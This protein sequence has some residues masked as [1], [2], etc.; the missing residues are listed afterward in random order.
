MPDPPRRALIPG[1]PGAGDKSI[2]VWGS[3]WRSPPSPKVTARFHRA[4]TGA[5]VDPEDEPFDEKPASEDQKQLLLAAIV[6]KIAGRIGP[7]EEASWSAA[8]A[9]ESAARARAAAQAREPRAFQACVCCAM[10]Q[11]TEHLHSEFLVGEKCTI[12]DRAKF[13]DCLSAEWYHKRWPL[14]PR[15]ELMS[16][17]VDFPHEDIDGSQTTTKILLHKRRV[18]P[19]ALTGGG[20]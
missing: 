7:E 16:S 15:E 3:G 9:E 5:T 17:A 12:K 1:A 4:Q 19:E 14:I 18:P 6:G 2:D 20:P 11:W 10:Q 13:A 8:A